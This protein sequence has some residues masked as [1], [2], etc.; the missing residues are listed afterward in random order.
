ME[1]W[2]R[3]RIVIRGHHV[4]EPD[5][6]CEVRE[7]RGPNAGRH[8]GFAGATAGTKASSI[9]VP[10][11]ASSTSNTSQPNLLGRVRLATYREVLIMAVDRIRPP[12]VV[13]AVVQTVRGTAA[14]AGSLRARLVAIV[15]GNQF[16]TLAGTRWAGQSVKGPRKVL[17]LQN[18]FARRAI[19]EPA[20]FIQRKDF[21]CSSPVA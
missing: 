15:D 1:L 21:Q 5:R 19:R 17:S 14:A 11:R 16:S 12:E 20:R 7:V 2:A 8:T 10:T 6:D 3:D 9:Q 13:A 4:G 18:G